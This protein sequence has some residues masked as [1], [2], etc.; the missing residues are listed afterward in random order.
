MNSPDVAPADR[1]ASF[2]VAIPWCLALA[3]VVLYAPTLGAGWL[4]YDDGWLVR[5][6]PFLLDPSWSSLRSIWAAFDRTTRLALGAEY[7]PVRD[8]TEWLEAR[9][10]GIDPGWARGVSL[11]LYVAGCLAVRRWLRAL[12]PT[13]P[14]T[15]E[16]AAFVFALHPVHAESVAWI[17]GRKDVLALLFS[18]LAL[19]VHAEAR[20]V[21]RRVWVP[22]LTAL[23]CG[24]KS[25][26]V[27]LPLLL[28]GHDW[29]VQRRSDPGEVGASAVVAIGALA[30]HLHV[31]GTV[32]MLSTLPG[33]SRLTAVATMAPVFVRYLAV[34]LGFEPSSLVYEVPV[35]RL[36]DPMSMACLAL[37][38][39]ATLAAVW[40]ARRRSR[41]PLFALGW[42]LLCLAPVSQ[43]LAPL[44]NRMAD[45]YLLLAVAGPCLGLAAAVMAALRG[46]RDGVARA[47]IAAL[48]ATVG[49]AGAVR[50]QTFADPVRLW[51]ETSLRAP[52]HT[53]PPYQLAMW[54]RDHGQ[55]ADAEV[56]FSETIRRD[57]WTTDIGRRAANNLAIMFAGQGRL[58]EAV[59]LLEVAAA[60][61]PTDLRI[62]GNLDRLRA[63]SAQPDRGRLPVLDDTVESEPTRVA[64][65]GTAAI[66]PPTQA[67]GSGG[68]P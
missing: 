33:G 56:A 25:V 45:R 37:F 38:A 11:F 12:L 47:A 24:S 65:P 20:L 43:V 18:G 29:F 2:D 40:C 6:N 39:T 23:A 10:V 4:D 22:V 66:E 61:Y 57:A 55:A 64:T 34:S 41:L 14:R 52:S 15:A 1:R 19:V 46:V 68:A 26:S 13:A 28:W 53:T 54:L 30:L 3:V 31:G 36:S 7:L 5:T 42:F 49:I 51:T 32:S 60:H 59:E 21:H 27:V 58:P 44:Q 63:A 62:A 67:P 17:A 9:L 16:V 8:T 50:A 48:V 35:R